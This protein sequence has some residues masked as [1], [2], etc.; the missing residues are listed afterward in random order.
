MRVSASPE[1][2]RSPLFAREEGGLSILLL[3]LTAAGT[4]LEGMA[5]E[6]DA[7]AGQSIWA[8]RDDV[9]SLAARATPQ[10]APYAKRPSLNTSHVPCNA[11]FCR[12]GMHRKQPSL[13]AQWLS[14]S[15]R[16]WMHTP[17]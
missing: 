15:R 13:G 9:H 16:N 10:L 12:H 3:V 14:T 1:G 2:A 6:P 11:P 8:N 17:I 7:A 5:D 4:E